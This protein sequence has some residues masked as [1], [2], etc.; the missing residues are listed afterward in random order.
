MRGYVGDVEDAVPY[1][2]DFHL[3]INIC[4]GG[5]PRPPEAPL[6]KGDSREAGGGFRAFIFFDN[7][8]VFL[9]AAKIHLSR[10]GSVTSRR[11]V[12]TGVLDCP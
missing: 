4:R 2:H 10:C 3:Q 12:G 9:P 1:D 5:R 7:P 11:C 8:S 6:P